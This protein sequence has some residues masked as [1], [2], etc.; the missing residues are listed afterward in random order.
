[1]KRMLLLLAAA[2]IALPASAQISFSPEEFIERY[3]DSHN[4]TKMLFYSSEDTAY[5]RAEMNRK[6][7]NASW[8]IRNRIFVLDTTDTDNSI[9]LANP[10]DAPLSDNKWLKDATHVWYTQAK[11]STSSDFYS[12]M[13]INNS[14]IYELGSVSVSKGI[15]QVTLA[16]ETPLMEYKL[17][18]QFGT[19]WTSTSRVI[20]ESGE[21]TLITHSR[22]V[23]VDGYGMVTTPKG[24]AKTLRLHS[25]WRT[26]FFVGGMEF[27][28]ETNSFNWIS[29]TGLSASV[30]ADSAL[31]P[32]RVFFWTPASSS[33]EEEK[34]HEDNTH[35]MQLSNN[36][37]SSE[38]TL[39][40][41][42]P[43]T[44]SV[45]AYL[46]DASGREVKTLFTGTAT[47]GENSISL[48]LDTL[49]NGTYFVRLVTHGFTST[50]K[51]IIAK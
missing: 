28:I 7:S 24:S 39:S 18:L 11:D 29:K 10:K 19:N 3:I 23:N 27:G 37:A 38:T 40:F 42:M 34:Q 12:F 35:M 9:L 46:A 32:S 5:I 6:G 4:S 33:V 14:G 36:P 44:E 30:T 48:N 20:D 50:Q 25:K 51:L 21:P 45:V 47:S 16:Y 8:D 41:T 26:G 31:K 49:P 1:M 15:P 13:K 17:P 43:R 2:L 22:T